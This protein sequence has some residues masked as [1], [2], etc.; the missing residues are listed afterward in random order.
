MDSNPLADGWWLTLVGQDF[1]LERLARMFPDP[2]LVV[3]A[4]EGKYWLSVPVPSTS[5]ADEA[6]AAG[7]R[8]SELMNGA[9]SLLELG[10]Q[11]VKAAADLLLVAPGEPR[12]YSFLLADGVQ[13]RAEDGVPTLI[14]GGVPVAPPRSP[15]PD[16]VALAQKDKAVSLALRLLHGEAGRWA[17]L[18]KV[19]EVVL[20]YGANKQPS[21]AEKKGL[22]TKEECGRFSGTACS[23]EVLGMKARHGVQT[24]ARPE[25]PMTLPEAEAFVRG[26]ARRWLESLTREAA[27]S[28]PAP[29]R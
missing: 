13:V 25:R 21:M 2:P 1:D 4:A 19:Y 18:Y 7:L 12:H 29:P 24:K 17:Q 26:M 8:L 27:G 16:W 14:M 3:R 22:A 15:A 6:R 5:T 9:A 20:K 28:P 23:P 10:H 11:P